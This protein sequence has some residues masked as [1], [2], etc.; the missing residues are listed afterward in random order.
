MLDDLKEPTHNTLTTCGLA[1]AI[2]VVAADRKY[3][4]T[5]KG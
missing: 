4:T 5:A 2:V 1:D 3:S